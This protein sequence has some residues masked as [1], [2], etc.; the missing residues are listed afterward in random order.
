MKSIVKFLA[1]VVILALSYYHI[2]MKKETESQAWSK[3]HFV[4]SIDSYD[5][6]LKNFPKG[7]NAKYAKDRIYRL[8]KKADFSFL[9][10]RYAGKNYVSLGDAHNYSLNNDFWARYFKYCKLKGRK[11]PYFV[12][13]GGSSDVFSKREGLGFRNRVHITAEVLF[14]SKQ[15]KLTG[16]ANDP[17][18]ALNRLFQRIAVELIEENEKESAFKKV[19]KGCDLKTKGPLYDKLKQLGLLLETKE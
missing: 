14:K 5:K 10:K 8:E 9:S 13:R 11:G 18:G 19:L 15:C 7:K 2:F 12:I 1:V 6:Y 3:A 17:G 4:N 16:K